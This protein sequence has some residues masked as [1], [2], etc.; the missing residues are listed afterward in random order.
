MDKKKK[1]LW[2]IVVAVLACC[3]LVTLMFCFDNIFGSKDTAVAT[4]TAT[5]QQQTTKQQQKTTSSAKMTE[6]KA[7]TYKVGKDIPSGKYM[8]E[9]TS[10]T[11]AYFCVSKDSNKKNIAFNDN[12]DI[13]RIIEIYDGEYLELSRCY[14]Y[15]LDEYRKYYT[16]KNT[17]TGVMLEVGVDIPEGEY[18]LRATSSTGGYYC[19]YN[20]L[21][22]D[23]IDSND[24]FDNQ[25]YVTISKGQYLVLTRC[26][27]DK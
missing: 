6:Y 5:T 15:P 12:F 2:V 26:K 25:T 22:Q 27:I 19:I 18:K 1:N 7:G 3:V 9:A 13:N 17:V 4:T 20:D 23:D 16:I 11:G 24:N 21:R 8:L 10:K 14:A